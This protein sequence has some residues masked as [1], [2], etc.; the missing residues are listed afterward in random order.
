[1]LVIDE[2]SVLLGSKLL[3]HWFQ[4]IRTKRI[5]IAKLDDVFQFLVRYEAV[6]VMI[7][8][9]DCLNYFD[10]LVVL[11]HGSDELIDVTQRLKRLVKLFFKAMVGAEVPRRVHLIYVL[12]ILQTILYV[13]I[14]VGHDLM[15]F[16]LHYRL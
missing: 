6:L 2:K 15:A 1:M 8:R 14:C 12:G 11:L 7:N 13:L 3:Q 10:H 9:T 5:R 16:Q 4:V